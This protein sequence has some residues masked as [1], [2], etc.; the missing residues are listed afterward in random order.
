MSGE[1]HPNL[2]AELR[3]AV[4][5]LDEPAAEQLDDPGLL[6]PAELSKARCFQGEL[7][8]RRYARAHA[9]LRI[10]LSRET[11]IAPACLPISAHPGKKPRLEGS[12]I[13]FNLSHSAHLG[14]VVFAQG[15][16]VGIDVEALGRPLDD[17]LSIAA[18]TMQAEELAALAAMPRGA[19]DAGFL[20]LWTAREALL[21]ALGTGFS[22]PA[23]GFDASPFLEGVQSMQWNGW[24]VSAV[25]SPAG[26][27]VSVAG[28]GT[29]W[30]YRLV[31]P[32][33][34]C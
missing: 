5:D 8:A 4:F 3:V 13:T 20:R 6:P 26:A 15:R 24:T 18:L 11:G 27:L 17:A 33:S 32:F 2:P 14:A 12:E 28:S 30:G 29:G 10:L 25:P 23:E 7:L 16:E 19:R 34:R 31:S 21:K 1:W 9:A 22:G